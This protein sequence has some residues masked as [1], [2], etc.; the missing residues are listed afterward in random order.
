MPKE[1][2]LEQIEAQMEKLRQKKDA[3]HE[4]RKALA[5]ERRALILSSQPSVSGTVV[6]P[7]PAILE[8]KAEQ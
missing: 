2:T 5:A 8:A 7:D 3:L 4:E 6:S 1:R